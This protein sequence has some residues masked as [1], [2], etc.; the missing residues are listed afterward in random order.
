LL[1]PLLALLA[2]LTPFAPQGRRLEKLTAGRNQYSAL[3]IP[4]S[5]R[6][7]LAEFVSILDPDD[8]GFAAYGPFVAICALQMHAREHDS[9][10]RRVEVDEAF[11]LFVSGRLAAADG[12]G[13][14]DDDGV[15]TLPHLRRVAATLKLDVADDLLRDMILEAN[16]GAGVGRGVRREEF[17]SIM[18]RAGVWR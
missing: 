10:A 15:I 13:G 6:K 11:R 18:R 9:D 4:P 3:G 17:E 5:S 1:V 16:G 7:Q 12:G 14:D 2:P 8:E